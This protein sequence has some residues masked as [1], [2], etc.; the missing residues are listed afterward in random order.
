MSTG[1]YVQ[2]RVTLFLLA[3]AAPAAAQPDPQ[4]QPQPQ[5]PQPQPTPSLE[6]RV[7]ALEIDPEDAKDENQ[8]LHSEVD[9]LKD[10]IKANKPPTSF[11]ALN[12]QITAFL[13]GASRFDDKQVSSPQGARIDDRLF[14]RTMEVDFRAAVDPY[15]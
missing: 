1:V 4:P 9:D 11:S 12:P 14:M 5:P 8:D 3:L 13:N 10:Q 6:D 2:V 7:K 15:A